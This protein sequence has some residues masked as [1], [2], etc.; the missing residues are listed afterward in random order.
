MA[1]DDYGN[2]SDGD[3]DYQRGFERGRSGG[4]DPLKDVADGLFFGGSSKAEQA[5]RE[6]GARQRAEDGDSF[7]DFDL[8]DIVLGSSDRS[9]GNAG[10]RRSD[11]GGGSGSGNGG[12]GA[13]G[14]G[15]EWS[16]SAS[17]T[18][19][20]SGSGMSDGVSAFLVFAL[21]LALPVAYVAGS[22][23]WYNSGIST[24]GLMNEKGFFIS[25]LAV[26]LYIVTLPGAL[27]G[28]IVGSAFMA[29][30]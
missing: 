23:Y 29:I 1:G 17:S 30:F 22:L 11:G 28:A 24:I 5:G 2:K 13:A 19:Y 8:V 20:G 3:R 12:A 9:D 15:G 26:I 10:T 6:A 21:F 18:S 27:I 7:M 14:S 4:V 16:G 25:F